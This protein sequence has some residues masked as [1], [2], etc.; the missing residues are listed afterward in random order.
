MVAYNNAE[1]KIRFA[2]VEA[3]IYTRGDEHQNSFIAP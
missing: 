2:V 3:M 1:M